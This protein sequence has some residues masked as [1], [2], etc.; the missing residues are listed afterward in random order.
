MANVVIFGVGRIA[1][2]ASVYLTHDSPHEVVA[3]T[4]DR[5]YI[6]SESLHGL[7]MI[8]IEDVEPEY[9]PDETAMFIPLSFKRMN[10][11]RAEKYREAKDRGY[12]L[13][14]YVSSHATTFPGFACGDNCF[15][16]EDNT[17]Q[18]YVEI[19]NN[20]VL[21]SGNHIGHGTVIKDHVMITS[22]VVISG[23]C[24]IGEFSFLGVNA[25]VRDET[26]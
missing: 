18:P 24:T 15:I 10:H 19:G 13:V 7:P 17:I 20:V 4:V 2:L 14:S 25:T 6:D 9:P 5:D 23:C 1:E 12:E 16:L 22:H 21:W 11:T 3:F 26:A 8:A